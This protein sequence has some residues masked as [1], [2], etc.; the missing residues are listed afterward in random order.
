M[1]LDLRIA[2]D[3]A[4]SSTDPIL[5]GHLRY[6]NNLDQ[7]LNDTDVD[8]IRK[9]RVDYNSNP[10]SAVSFMTVIPSTSGRLHSEFIRLLFL[11]GHRETDGFFCNFRSSASVIYQWRI[12]PLSPRGV[13]LEPQ[14]KKRKPAR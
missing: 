1:V 2:H 8:K 14:V 6:P 3:R 12:L 5:N 9:Y 4:G 11:Q 13:L 10:P 7:S